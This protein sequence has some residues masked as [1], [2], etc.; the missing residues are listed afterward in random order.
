MGHNAYKEEDQQWQNTGQS[1]PKT[2]TCIFCDATDHRVDCRIYDTIDKR[3]RLMQEK[4]LCL[5]CGGNDHYARNCIKGRCNICQGMKHHF[6]LCPKRFARMEVQE[7]PEGNNNGQQTLRQAPSQ[8]PKADGMKQ[9]K[10]KNQQHPFKA[11]VA[12][13]L[14]IAEGGE[15]PRTGLDIA[16]GGEEPTSIFHMEKRSAF[17]GEGPVLLLT[18][19]AKIYNLVDREWTEVEKRADGCYVRLPF[20]ESHPPL[21]TNKAIATKRLVNI[22]QS[23]KSKSDLLE[24]YDDII[25]DQFHKN[26]I[27]E[28]ISNSID[29][30]KRIHYIPHQPVITPQKETT[31]LRIVFDA[32]S[33]F[34]NSPSLNDVLYQGPSILPKLYEMLIRFRTAKY[35]ATADVEKA[36]LQVHLKERDRDVTRFLWVRDINVP[37]KENNVI[38]LPFYKNDVWIECVSLSLSRNH[39]LPGAELC[40]RR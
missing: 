15:E 23:L 10:S 4:L 3:R 5:N 20:K 32:S 17:S 34:K 31:K 7:R 14:D 25:K 40:I 35:V 33:H 29:E 27:E 12:K 28:V 9:Q 37:P 2:T 36:L 16:E 13:G 30:G 22:L 39:S 26:I 6:T 19:C 11:T 8:A 24:K 21:P 1:R 18:G 38:N